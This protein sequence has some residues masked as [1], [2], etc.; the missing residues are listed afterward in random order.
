MSEARVEK[1][2]DEAG[3]WTSSAE[4]RVF[5]ERRRWDVSEC[6]SKEGA[7]DANPV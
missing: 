2:E 6:A 1:D 5:A 7:I 3:S 4:S